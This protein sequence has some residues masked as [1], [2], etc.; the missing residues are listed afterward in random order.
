MGMWKSVR[1]HLGLEIIEKGSVVNI[2]FAI[3][4]EGIT[5]AQNGRIVLEAINNEHN[6]L[7]AFIFETSI[8][9]SHYAINGFCYWTNLAHFWTLTSTRELLALMNYK[10][11]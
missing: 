8:S 10:D 3:T 9:I 1:N 11:A 7:A 6:K 2:S 5:T 4:R